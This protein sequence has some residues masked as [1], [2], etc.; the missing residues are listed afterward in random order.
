MMSRHEDSCQTRLRS[1][2]WRKDQPGG[3]ALGDE[4]NG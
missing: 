2:M 1:P 4:R 3:I